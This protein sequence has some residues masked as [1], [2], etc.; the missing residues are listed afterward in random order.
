MFYV[1]AMDYKSKWTSAKCHYVC[2]GINYKNYNNKNNSRHVTEKNQFFCE[3]KVKALR[4]DSV[5]V[6]LIDNSSWK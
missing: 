3:V 6:I 4:R 2:G 5:Y 1:F